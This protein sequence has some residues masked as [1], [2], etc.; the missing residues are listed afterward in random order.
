MHWIFTPV[1]AFLALVTAQ[2]AHAIPTLIGHIVQLERLDFSNAG[3][4]VGSTNLGTSTVG[5]GVE[6][7]TGIEPEVFDISADSISVSQ[8]PASFVSF[9]PNELDEHILTFTGSSVIVDAVLQSGHGVANLTQANVSF[10]PHHVSIVWADTAWDG[11]EIVVIDL[12][13]VPEPSTAALL[14]LGL[15]GIGVRRRRRRLA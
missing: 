4:F 10:G 9:F 2:S 15:V 12:T 3:D 1:P 6:F 8:D 5:S 7:T 13:L 11:P 14:A